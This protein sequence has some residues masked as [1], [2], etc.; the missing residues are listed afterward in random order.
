LQSWFAGKVS[1]TPPLPP[2]AIGELELTGGRLCHFFDR[3]I[4]SYMYRFD[5][6]VVSVYVMARDGLELSVA[7]PA[8]E[9]E[10]TQFRGFSNIV[11]SSDDLVFA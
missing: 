3:A 8:G 7:A 4:A 6:R 9:T 2:V 1:F 11:V 5:G 10:P